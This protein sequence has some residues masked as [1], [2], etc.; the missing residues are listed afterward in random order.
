MPGR[1]KYDL[2][3]LITDLKTAGNSKIIIFSNETG[4]ARMH[5]C[6]EIGAQAFIEKALALG[7]L[8]EFIHKVF[9]NEDLFIF[10]SE[11][12]P[13]I[14]FSERQAEILHCISDGKENNEIAL[15]L[16]SPEKVSF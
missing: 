11:E 12:L 1:E 5:R 4:W 7:R 2:K 3:Y 6:L 8:S 10:T 15:Y 14:Q 13:K 9:E 16:E